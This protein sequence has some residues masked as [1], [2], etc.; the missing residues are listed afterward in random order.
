[1]T[2]HLFLFTIG[3]VQSFIA[4]ARKTHDLYAGSAMLSELCNV[5]MQEFK[6]LMN[7]SFTDD[8]FISP[9]FKA[10]R[11]PNRFLATIPDSY[12]GRLDK[13]GGDVANTVR[14]HFA[15]EWTKG[16][17]SKI[18]N[19]TWFNGQVDNFLE[20]E[21]L[22]IPFESSYAE[23]YRHIE[24]TM[25]SVK[26]VRRF[27][28]LQGGAGEAG[29]KCSIDGERNIVVYRRSQT[30]DQARLHRKLHLEESR[31]EVYVV[32]GDD[33]SRVKIWELQQGEGLSAVSFVKRKYAMEKGLREFPSTA[34]VC[35]YHLVENVAVKGMPEFQTLKNYINGFQ[36]EGAHWDEQLLYK[37]NI[38]KQYFQKYLFCRKGDGTIDSRLQKFRDH[39]DEFMKAKEAL[40]K[41]N[42]TYLPFTKYY[43]LMQ[44]DGDYMG[45]WLSGTKFRTGFDLLA[46]HR[47][48][49]KAIH[50]F[51]E[52]AEEHLVPPRG[53]V[54]Y[55]GGEDFMAFINLHELGAVVGALVEMYDKKLN[56][57]LLQTGEIVS[58]LNNPKDRFSF[59]AGIIIAHYKEPLT[60]VVHRAGE[61]EKEAKRNGR[62]GFAL[63]AVKHSG[64][65]VQCA[66]HWNDDAWKM[67]QEIVKAIETD[68]SS[69]WIRELMR[70]L[71]RFDFD[72]P[73]VMVPLE[74]ERLIARAC[75]LGHN[76]PNRKKG[77][78]EL[79][80][81]VA[82]IY[83][84]AHS[85]D[86]RQRHRNFA[87]MLEM[88]DFIHRK[89]Q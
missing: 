87:G 11:I 77:I 47:K 54:V 45:D 51:A 35:L 66:Y 21:W 61:I 31:N 46:F 53:K 49:T 39:Y 33:E 56:T 76:D 67:M 86:A 85:G 40:E 19:V 59:S 68:F 25:G 10:G 17:D 34:A 23:T 84:T 58:W 8:L 63:S 22:V 55:A 28:Q 7:S 5:G 57:E 82:R 69:T 2:D 3:P 64:S 30:D 42:N 43:A 15:R 1:M 83:S 81:T 4:Q 12:T 71:H 29:R 79:T 50:E 37:E 38:N 36:A 27:V 80:E 16:I 89:K 75:R 65:V 14:E 78:T 60:E 74:T 62:S 32:A 13:I 70:M 48:L 44:F 88:C 73:E 72:P 26:S 52:E 18:K 41:K 24:S 6:E 20:L 9:V